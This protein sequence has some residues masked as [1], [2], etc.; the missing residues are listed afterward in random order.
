M[1]SRISLGDSVDNPETKGDKTN[2][3]KECP[4]NGCG[5]REAPGG[6]IIRHTDVPLYKAMRSM[7][8]PLSI[9]G[10]HFGK[11]FSDTHG[12]ETGNGS[13]T[14]T[15]VKRRNKLKIKFSRSQI[16]ATVVLGTYI[17]T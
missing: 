15:Q 8:I 1:G 2:N 10:M 6:G 13:H 3:T 16:Y 4:T 5:E 7:I 11:K 17:I 9:F 14:G 12:Q